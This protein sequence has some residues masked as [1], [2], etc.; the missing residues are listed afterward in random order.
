MTVAIG[1]VSG[2]GIVLAADSRTTR[3]GTPVRVL[4]DYTHKVFRVGRCGI[5]TY[6]WAFLANRNIAH[7]MAQ[8]A[9]DLDGA[10]PGPE[11]MAARLADFFGDRIEQHFADG[12]DERPEEGREVLGFVVAG[13][14][15]G[16][17]KAL[18]VFLP[19][20]TVS[21]VLRSDSPGA[22][23]RGQ[24]DVIRRLVKGVDI[25][26]LE[27]LVGDGDL[28][29]QLDALRP[30]IDALEYMIPFSVMNL[31]DAVDFAVFAIRTTIDTQRLTYGTIGH[32]GSWPGVGGPI[33]IGLITARGGFE[34]IQR[35][36]L[37]GE[38]PAGEAESI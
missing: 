23:W 4:S 27:H 28:R 1:V 2:D 6:G 21:V 10:E 19:S 7:H 25:D 24:T 31:Q 15:D 18:D 13:F 17:G 26:L 11:E 32:P 16:E 34:W 12:R 35:T 38:R 30:S 22:V 9:I 20:R 14:D 3:G 8:F 36:E 37:H 29:S 33:E 5:V